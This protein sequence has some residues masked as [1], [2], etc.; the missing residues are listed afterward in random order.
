MD[1]LAIL[2]YAHLDNAL[3]LKSFSEALSAQRNTRGIILHGDSLYTQRLVQTGML[4]ED[5]RIR[6]TKDL[7][8]RLI[9]LLAD[10]GVSAVGIN[11]YQK[12]IIT[13]DGK[14]LKVNKNF[15]TGFPHNTHMVLS[16]LV[17]NSQ[18]KQP[19]IFDLAKLAH[20]LRDELKL[21]EIFIFSKN[22]DDEIMINSKRTSMV[23]DDLINLQPPYR[24]INTISFRKLPELNGSALIQ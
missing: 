18:H 11:G 9:S 3:F 6:S 7:N 17:G 2:D 16:N 1:Y 23:P 20:I 10:N 15:L 8:H 24:I 21:N 22:E 5:A 14:F 4:T 12:D 13:H 19:I